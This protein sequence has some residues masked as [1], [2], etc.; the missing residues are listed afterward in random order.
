M[1][2]DD[3]EG[4]GYK[5][6]PK[7]SQFK[8][9]QSGNPKGRPKGRRNNRSI[10]QDIMNEKIEVKEGNKSRRLTKQEA[11]L[12]RV[13]TDA[14]KGDPKAIRQIDEWNKRYNDPKPEQE[15]EEQ[16]CGVLV[17]SP[18]ETVEEWYEK[19]SKYRIPHDPLL[20]PPKTKRSTGNGPED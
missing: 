9:G 19:A 8:P 18:P 14:L 20:D 1:S 16:T 4:V 15:S 10:F 5:R 6:P 2:T 17:V 3:D 11:Y 12:R 7:H 13:I